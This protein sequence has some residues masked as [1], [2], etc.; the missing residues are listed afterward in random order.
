MD[1]KKN[2]FWIGMTSLFTDISSEMIMSLLPLF[3]TAL[4][5]SRAMIGLIEGIAEF[6]ASIFKVLSGWVSD[7]LQSRKGLVVAGYAL[8]TA[9]KPLIALANV[10]HQV[11]SVRFVDRLGKGIR[12]APRDALVA[13]SVEVHERGRAFGFQR[14]MD[15]FGAVIGTLL[16][17]LLVFILSE[18]TDL[19]IVSQYRTIFWLSVVPGVL[20]VL[21][22]AFMVKEVRGRGFVKPA[23]NINWR[24]LDSGFKAFLFVSV[25]FELSNFSYAIF[26][27]RASN[28]GVIAALIP[29]IYL[30][31]N[32]IYSMLSQPLGVMADKIGK[33]KVLFFGYL[34][35]SLM[36]L[37]FAFASHSIFAWLLF[38]LYGV[39]SAI[40]NTTP[41]AL[42]ADL[43]FPDLRGTA[44]G[45]YYMLIGFVALPTSAI[46]GLL[47]DRFGAIT[48]FSYGAGLS[49]LAALLVIVLI[50]NKKSI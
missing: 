30:V 42:L 2:I 23:S 39:V 13:D 9:V 14:G 48:A 15:T 49:A 5:A 31:Y 21:S 11:L 6:T 7:R 26:I 36:C 44:Y 35:S 3:L 12:N 10:W 27:L 18:F 33:K 37:G 16:A 32:I 1:K 24:T 41:R 40:T 4:G 20:G 19:S 38:A 50:P 34:L 46:A 25:I 47:W 17:S 45:V 43:V 28:L 8:S 22:F 29:I